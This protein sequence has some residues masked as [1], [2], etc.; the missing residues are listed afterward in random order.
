MV[1]FG[2][3]A[4]IQADRDFWSAAAFGVIP[5]AVGIGY[6]LDFKLTRRDLRASS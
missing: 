1:T 3:V 4:W 2:L 5:L 6:Y